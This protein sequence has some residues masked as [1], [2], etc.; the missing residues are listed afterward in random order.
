MPRIVKYIPA[1]GYDAR[2]NYNWD[3]WLDG[4]L[5]KFIPGKHF[6]SVNAIRGSAFRA[7]NVRGVDVTVVLRGDAVYIQSKRRRAKRKAVR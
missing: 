1:A 2:R 7:A 3:E 4:K 6:S 5:R